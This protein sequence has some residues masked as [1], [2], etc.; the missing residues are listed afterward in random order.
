MTDTTFGV[1]V[2]DGYQAGISFPLLYQQGYRFAAV[3]FTEGSTY[4]RDQA[5]EWAQAVRAAGLLPGAY[6]WLTA[7]DGAAQAR[8]FH[9]NLQKVGG[10]AGL[11]IQL[12]C[13]DDGY[14]PQ[15]RAWA[16]EWD[17]LTGGHPFF[18]YSGH[19]WWSSSAMSSVNGAAVTPYLWDSHYLSADTDTLPDDPAA[20]ASRIPS[21]WWTPGYGGWPSST[22]LQ[23]T[24]KGDAGGL[25]N[26]VDLNVFRGT[27]DALRALASPGGTVI[28]YEQYDRDRVNATWDLLQK[29]ATDVAAMKTALADLAAAATAGGGGTVDTTLLPRLATAV[30]AAADSLAAGG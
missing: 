12:D 26:K 22:I 18:I 29:V 10:P 17:R 21:T 23:F 7:S 11:L 25:A 30:Q 1:D 9:D 2:H 5:D 14:G 3:K 16:A 15:I 4:V 24:S 27:L 6:H 8:W 13:E 28:T 19:W 20:F